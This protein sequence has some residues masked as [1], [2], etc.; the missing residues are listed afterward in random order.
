MEMTAL[1]LYMAR[2]FGD[3]LWVEQI[4]LHLLLS[5]SELNP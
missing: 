4:F 1:E 2:I 3:L 5:L